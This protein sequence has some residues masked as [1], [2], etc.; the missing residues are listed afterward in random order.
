MVAA[1]SLTTTL[2]SA[3]PAWTR[4][5][6]SATADDEEDR[7]FG[8][9]WELRQARR[10][11]RRDGR[12]GVPARD[13]DSLPFD[14]REILA[15]AE[16][17]VERLAQTWKRQDR[18]LAV[19]LG[20]LEQRAVAGAA[21]LDDAAMQRDAALAEHER[22]KADEDE[23]LT[24]LQ[25]QVEA[26]PTA[27]TPAF[28]FE[29]PALPTASPPAPPPSPR[30]EPVSFA[31]E[32]CAVGGEDTQAYAPIT[33]DAAWRGFGPLVYWPLIVLIVLGEI[34]L[35]A[36]A[37]RL[38]HESDL[39]TYAM[40]VTVVVGLVAFAHG[41]GLLLSRPERTG[42]EKALVVTFIVVPLGAIAVISFVR[43][44]Y[45]AD[46]GGDAGVGPL[47][48]TLAFG[49]INLLV[50]GAAAGLSYL[51]HDPRALV[52]R[53][54]AV[55]AA[56]RERARV[57]RHLAS[58]QRKRIQREHR[59]EDDAAKRREALQRKE[60]AAEQD[61]RR[62]EL[63]LQAERHAAALVA[64]KDEVL[65]RREQ[66]AEAM[67]PLLDAARA[68]VQRIDELNRLVDDARAELGE[69]EQRIAMIAVE[70]RALHD[71]TFAS[72][73][74]VKATRDR[75]VFAYCSANVRARAV[76]DAPRCFDAVPPLRLPV[77]F[78]TAMSEVSR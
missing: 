3:E 45:L 12:A 29:E 41:L 43:Y 65:L 75:L 64:S 71:S 6:A 7:M 70:Q 61:R 42:V 52:N 23:R 22:R 78:E 25:E 16:G 13:Q 27:D 49:L 8:S 53:R 32:S 39:L 4:D 48:G 26:L 44:G 60:L 62:R 74:E 67:R 30:A 10:K 51:H 76:H 11:G 35:N 56:E 33:R 36:F 20:D 19:E 69:V 38:F 14:L 50:F 73:R 17:C 72:F 18:A 46:V 66:I 37:F 54:A 47:L 63:E 5:G 15:K 9:R 55:R 28:R 68:R 24:R 34:P 77:E 58:E 40:T 1:P 31:A 59:L 21:R 2:G 57:E